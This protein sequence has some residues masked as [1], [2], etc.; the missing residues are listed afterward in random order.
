MSGADGM[1]SDTV[2]IIDQTTTYIKQIS[3][4]KTNE[5]CTEHRAHYN[6]LDAMPAQLKYREHANESQ[7]CEFMARGSPQAPTMLMT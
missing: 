3:A 4:A 6:L 2:V 7:P 1:E 5:A